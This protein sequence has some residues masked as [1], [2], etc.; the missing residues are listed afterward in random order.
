MVEEFDW[1]VVERALIDEEEA[2]IDPSYRY[3][4]RDL[5]L[6]GTVEAF[7]ALS[8]DEFRWGVDQRQVEVRRIFRVD[9]QITALISIGGRQVGTLGPAV[10]TGRSFSTMAHVTVRRTGGGTEVCVF[11]GLVNALTRSGVHPDPHSG[12]W[13][14]AS[15]LGRQR[16]DLL[17]GDPSVTFWARRWDLSPSLSRLALLLMSAFSIP[18]IAERSELSVKS[19]RTYAE[20]IFTRARINRRSELAMRA[21]RDGRMSSDSGRNRGRI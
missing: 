12:I 4:F 10:A 3:E 16:E 14:P 8:L 20:R 9:A 19:V 2:A 17:A 11:S 15:G 5:P 7:P 13:G 6:L 21:L 18:E 1:E